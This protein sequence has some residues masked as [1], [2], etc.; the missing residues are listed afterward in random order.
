MN[1]FKLHKHHTIQTG[2]QAATVTEEEN[3]IIDDF[4]LPFNNN[5]FIQP[6]FTM[7]GVNFAI[8]T[9]IVPLLPML[10]LSGVNRFH[11]P[12]SWNDYHIFEKPVTAA[13]TSP[14]AQE[15]RKENPETHRTDRQSAVKTI[16]RNA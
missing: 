12:P 7:K 3:Q 13:D 15:Q 1:I 6:L 11:S 4:Y 16:I 8:A 10:A 9:G 2:I 5:H 14:A